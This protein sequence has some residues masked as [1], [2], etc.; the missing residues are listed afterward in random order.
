MITIEVE[1]DKAFLTKAAIL[2]IVVGEFIL[3]RRI[4]HWE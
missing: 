2:A 3:I 4:K 1:V